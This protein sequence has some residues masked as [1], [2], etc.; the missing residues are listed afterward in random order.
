MAVEVRVPGDKSITHRALILAAI[1][2]GES[3][4]AGALVSLD[5]RSTAG[6]L[7]KLGVPIPD[8]GR[9]PFAIRGLGLGG[10]QQPDGILDCGNSGTTARLLLGL[11]AGSGIRAELTGDESLRRR[12]MRRVTAPLSAAGAHFRELGEPDH[13]PIRIEGGRLRPITFAAPQASAQVK[14]A[15]LLAALMAGETARLS[16]PRLS[17][18]HT[19]RM[20]R[21]MG[22]P[23]VSTRDAAGRP[24]TTLEP[25]TALEP[26]DLAI[27]GDPSSAAFLLARPMMDPGVAVRI[28]A[29]GINPTRT[30]FLDV[31][32]RMGAAITAVETR[33]EGGEPVADLIAEYSELS[34]TVVQGAEIPRLID[35]VPI[36][37]ALAATARGETRIEGA[38]EVR[39][40]ESD[41][42]AVMAENLRAVGGKAEELP[43][44]LVVQGSDAPLRGTVRTL[45]DHR[46]AMAFGVLGAK[47][48]NDI[49]IDRPDVADVSFPGFWET[50]DRIGAG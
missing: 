41:R 14:S 26:L 17:R 10:L 44:G 6:C 31:A 50:M 9:G 2:G 23:C 30:G 20:L 16:E 8:F 18:D 28:P 34:G 19:E 21:A 3:R 33:E 42:L 46:I 27:P 43:D 11:L 29:V 45:G 37:A 22:V 35:E 38:G 24:A 5:T 15:L 32:R 7:R 25:V 48:G 39:F 36:I 47:P 12:P 13:L 4:V 1:A 49:R 40:K